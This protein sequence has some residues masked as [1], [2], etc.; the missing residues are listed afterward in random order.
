MHETPN[1]MAHL[2]QHRLYGVVVAPAVVVGFLIQ[3]VSLAF[4]YFGWAAAVPI[5]RN[6]RT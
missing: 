2:K 5:C 4:P 3:F 1:F 6:P